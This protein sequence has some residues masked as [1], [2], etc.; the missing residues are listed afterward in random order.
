MHHWM[1]K[2][3]IL[4]YLICNN[5]VGIQILSKF[6]ETALDTAWHTTDVETAGYLNDG[7]AEVEPYCNTGTYFN[8]YISYFCL[9]YTC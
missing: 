2:L 8:K 1:A 6:E 9:L 7:L 3:L 5:A 4:C